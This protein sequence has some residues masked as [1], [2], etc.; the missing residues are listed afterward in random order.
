[1][2]NYTVESATDATHKSTSPTRTLTVGVCIGDME[3]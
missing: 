2:H 3:Q 1:V